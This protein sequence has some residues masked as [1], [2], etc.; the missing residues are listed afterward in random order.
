MD[1]SKSA[2]IKLALE[3]N[4]L[5]FGQFTL[6]SGRISPYFFNTGLFYHADSIRFLGQLY[7]QALIKNNIAF[8]HLFGPAYKGIPL[9][10]ATAVALAEQGVDCTLTFNRKE[11][12]DH[13]EGGILIGAPLTGR[14]VL[15]DDVI[16]AGTAFRHAQHLINTN[17]GKLTT[18]VITLDRCEVG[19]NNKLTLNEIKQEGITVLSLMTVYDLITY[20]ES[21]KEQDLIS[22]MKNYLQQYGYP[23]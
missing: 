3:R 8:E 18:V 7:A 1:K 6:K 14:T 16:S 4:I 17:G 20:L 2:L 21:Q 22:Q 19:L 11:E 10:T 15:I 13:G 12:K 5:R 9:A 23:N